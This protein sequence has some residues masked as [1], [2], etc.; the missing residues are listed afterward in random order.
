MAERGEYAAHR[1]GIWHLWAAV[2]PDPYCGAVRCT[3]NAV[4]FLADA[5]CREPWWPLPGVIWEE[6]AK[7]RPDK[8]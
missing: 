7:Q 4:Q 8:G 6:T 2:P 1:G 3:R 5:N